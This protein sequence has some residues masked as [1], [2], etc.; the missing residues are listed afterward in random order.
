MFTGSQKHAADDRSRDTMTVFVTIEVSPYHSARGELVSG[1]GNRACVRV[2]DAEI[3]GRV[4]AAQ[5]S[6]TDRTARP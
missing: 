3:C 5:W 2:G 1:C 4:I 6:L